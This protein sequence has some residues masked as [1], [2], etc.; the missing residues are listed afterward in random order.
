M[1]R[2]KFHENVLLTF[3]CTQCKMCICDK[4]R[5]TRHTDHTT[6]DIH[7]AAELH[8]VPI[9][10]TVQKMKRKTA[11]YTERVEKTKESLR[12]GRER[13]ASA[14]TKVM[15]SVEELIRLLQ[16]HE[17]AMIAS[18][19][20]FDG[21]VQREHAAQL[22]HLE[23]SRNQLQE[24]VE[25]CEGILLRNKSVEILQAQND[26][27][28][29]SRCPTNTETLKI[30]KPSHVRYEI[31][32]ENLETMRSA[33]LA[34]GQVV[35]SNTDP[36]QSVSKSVKGLRKKET[37]FL[38][39]FPTRPDEATRRVGETPGN[40][41]EGEVG[42]EAIIKVKTKDSE[43][44]Q[45]HD[46]NDRIDMKVQLPSGK[47][48]S[49]RVTAPGKNGEYSAVY[50]P[51]CVGKHEVLIEVNGEPL[52]GSPWCFEVCPHRYRHLFSFGSYGKGQ[53]QF[54]EPCSIA[55]DEKSGKV[56]VADRKRVQ[57]FSLNGTYLT[58]INT[59]RPIESSSVSFTKLGELIVIASSKI[60]CFDAE[61]YKFLRTVTNKHLKKPDH[62][63]I[64]GDGRLMVCDWGDNTVKVLSPDGSQLLLT[65]I[66][67]NSGTPFNP[68]HHQNTF[69]VCFADSSYS[70][71]KYVKVFGEDGV[72]LYKIFVG[73]C[74]GHI[75]IDR[76]NNLVMCSG[77]Q[78]KLKMF[79]LDGTLVN[80]TK[81]Y[82][83]CPHS[84][85]VSGTG[86]LF[87]IDK[88]LHCVQ[89]FQ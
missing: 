36:L 8:K 88:S 58:E 11:D 1:C 77:D 40:E 65:I 79:N 69:F 66:D 42:I 67:P 48:L 57:L 29:R 56:A 89:V 54:R 14:R 23:I 18:L 35:V 31:N 16:E 84:V 70:F 5:Q 13:V 52:S 30:Y 75:A 82:G 60:S 19:D 3:Y 27:I 76:F 46:E 44:N 41:L 81:V 68:L 34:L 87:V 53:G 64:A 22:E 61:S 12:K 47:E 24:H 74:S 32:K 9:E 62:L 7:Q 4:C 10:E 39:L 15:T 85:A 38:D 83:F 63:T 45:C 49:Y 33:V 21:K 59:K 55:I 73:D 80:D 51:N 20:I 17:K 28:R 72:F 2:E 26:F 71:L 6:M 37:W 78:E 86:Q 50:T 25:W 43:G